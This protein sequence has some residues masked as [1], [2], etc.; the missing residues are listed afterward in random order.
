MKA[1]IIDDELSGREVLKKLV[2]LN[3]PEVTVVNTL[4]A[5]E[6]GLQSI[7]EDKP[8]LVFLDI[9]MPN[10]SGFDLLNQ[11]DKIDFE[12]I[13]VTAHDSFAIRAFKYAAVDY[14]LKPIKVTEL[15]DAVK[16]ADE[17]IK[18]NQTQDNVKFML[19]KVS[20]V[21]KVFLNNKILLP[22]LG[23]YNII[24]VSDITYC[25]SES[26]YTRFHFADGKNLVVSKTLKEFESILLENNF[27]RIHRSY[28]INLNCIA[29][30]NKGKGGEVVMKDGAILEVSR[31]KKEEFLKL[32]SIS[33][34]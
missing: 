6:T 25:K 3:C 30:Y 10:A 1:I 15:I 32:F 23:G 16:R 17:R 8:D 4:N 14:L 33:D 31:E 18:N 26:N 9:Q 28:I 19:E 24:E 22:T 29:K 5:I 13:F 20:P 11:I 27:F 34:S 12:I 2:Q 21:K 7:N